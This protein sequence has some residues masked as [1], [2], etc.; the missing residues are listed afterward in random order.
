MHVDGARGLR[1]R[2][3]GAAEL[4]GKL[5]MFDN[6]FGAFG[7]AEAMLEGGGVGI[8]RG[9]VR[10]ASGVETKRGADEVKNCRI[11]STIFSP[12]SLQ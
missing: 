9:C 5:K 7:R 3:L 10:R 4:A 2:E 11:R 1:V 6:T 12:C 8:V